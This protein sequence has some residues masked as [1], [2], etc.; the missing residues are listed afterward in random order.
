MLDEWYV[1]GNMLLTMVGEFDEAG[2]LGLIE[3]TFGALPARVVPPAPPPQVPEP[4]GGASFRGLLREV[5]G[6]G[7]STGFVLRAPGEDTPEFRVLW[8][9]ESYLASPY[10][11]A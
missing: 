5:I 2:A 4:T 1:P 11:S 8:L 9:V 3:R 6:K 7:T 10:L